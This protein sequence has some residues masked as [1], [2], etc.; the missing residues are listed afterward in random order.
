MDKINASEHLGL[1][2]AAVVVAAAVGVFW[3][4][5][6]KKPVHAQS[7]T[8]VTTE[9]AVAATGAQVTPTEPKLRVEP[10]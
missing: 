4:L 9:S 5:G 2:C 1:A 3:L 10:K 6:G 8:S 7:D